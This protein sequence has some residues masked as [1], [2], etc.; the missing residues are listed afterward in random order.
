VDPADPDERPLR[1]RLLAL[2][3]EPDGLLHLDYHPLNVMAVGNRISGVLDWTNARAGDPRA[4]LA[5]TVS[6]LRLAPST[7][8][9]PGP[10][11]MALRTILELTW[12]LGYRRERGW[13][14]QMAPF[15]AWA[16][17]V[18][19]RDLGP[20]PGRSTEGISAR[21]YARMRRWTATWK[22]RAALTPLSQHW[23][24]G[25]GG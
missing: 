16:G 5:R 12:R 1:E 15:Y 6:I 21:D 22:R 24:R 17:A 20:R 14:E 4:D 2:Q 18:L 9:V 19:L 3:R 23:E 11:L 13:P 10:A 8:D 7:T 25:A